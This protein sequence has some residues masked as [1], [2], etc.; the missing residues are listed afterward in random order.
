[1]A[2][3]KG[4]EYRIGC[5]IRVSTEEQAQNLEGSIRNQEDRLKAHVDFKNS[6]GAFGEIIEIFIDRARS[7]KDTNRPELQRLLR[8]I[9]EGKINFV[10]ATELSRIS[11]SI[12]DFAEIWDLMQSHGCGFQSLRENF[13][14]TTAA[15]EL[16]LFSMANL[17]Q[18]ERRQVSERVSLNMNARAKR[19]LYNGGVVPFGYSLITDKP[20]YLNV[21]NDHAEI[22]R[23]CFKAFLKEE[24]LSQAAKW[25]NENGYK[26]ERFTRGGGKFRLD[27]FTVDNLHHILRNKAYIG[28]RSF[29]D[30]GNEVDVKAVWKPIITKAVF[31]RVQKMLTQNKSRKKSHSPKRHPYLLSGITFCE[32]CGDH[33]SG[34]SAH[35]KNKKIPY[36][37]HSWRT[38]RGS[39]LSQSSFECGNHRRFLANKLEGIVLKE[40][41]NLIQSKSLAEKLLKEAWKIHKLSQMANPLEKLKAKLYG[42]NSQL[43]AL[44]ERL[45]QLPKSVS[46]TPIFKQMEKIEGL[47][48]E[49]ESQLSSRNLKAPA[50]APPMEL[51]N[52]RRFLMSLQKLISGEEHEIKSKILRR[53]IHRIDVGK[54]S[55]TISYKLDESSLLREP[56]ELGSRLFLCPKQGKVLEFKNKKG[57]KG[58]HP[59]ASDFFNVRCSKSLTNGRGTRTR[60]S[61][62]PVM[63]RML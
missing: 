38:K 60:T 5:Y 30:K 8:F 35:G 11:R 42:Y 53:L 47:K 24:S 19:G 54:E 4:S 46:A 21:N 57:D 40:V 50:Q 37:E 12:K 14:T 52:Y 48:S 1:M 22:V 20:G 28:V 58:S 31:D 59:V 61:D 62:P 23:A 2:R 32:V 29:K 7:G 10:M 3:K 13:D 39:T 26:M 43:D 56:I 36:Y 41:E 17:A 45:A 27:Y 34:K 49:I 33:L 16:V 15:G 55:I 25:L 51:E 9:R 6:Q 18:F 63:S 44:S